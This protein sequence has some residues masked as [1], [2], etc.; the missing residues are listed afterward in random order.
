MELFNEQRILVP[1]KDKAQGRLALSVLKNNSDTPISSIRLLHCIE[2]K[3]ARSQYMLA[4]SVISIVDKQSD[5]LNK[6]HQYLT[7][8]ARELEE[9]FPNARVSVQASLCDSVSDAIV[10][11][12]ENMNATMILL[13][14][15]PAQKKHWF[16]PGLTNRVLRISKC[17]V[18]IVKPAMKVDDLATP[19]MVA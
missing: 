3:L 14:T 2:D 11:E 8:F 7:E 5:E 15:D 18:Q 16:W 6:A 4:L 10:S 1:I 17:P 13:V 9:E 12:S 19:L